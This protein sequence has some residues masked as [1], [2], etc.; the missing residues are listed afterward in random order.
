MWPR[1]TV[2]CSLSLF[3]GWRSYYSHLY[4]ATG[5]LPKANKMCLAR[6]CQTCWPALMAL[7]QLISSQL[8]H[9]LTRAKV[10]ARSLPWEPR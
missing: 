6:S 1:S 3:Q 2:G 5:D 8:S 9:Y 10:G 4:R 7:Y